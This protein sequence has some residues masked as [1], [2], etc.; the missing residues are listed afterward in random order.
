MTR[1][2]SL[3]VPEQDPWAGLGC[4]AQQYLAHHEA[5]IGAGVAHVVGTGGTCRSLRLD[6]LGGAEILQQRHT[7]LAAEV[8]ELDVLH[9]IVKEDALAVG[10]DAAVGAVQ[11]LDQGA[12]HIGG[13]R[14]LS[15]GANDAP[16][17]LQ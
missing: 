6:A 15:T 8:H 17:Q 2:V 3:S 9:A 13:S 14:T 4:L 10:I 1:T 5:A 16:S 12:R 11:I 7:V